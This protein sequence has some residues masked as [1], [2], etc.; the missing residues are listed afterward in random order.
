MDTSKKISVI[1]GV[2]NC[3]DTV[4]ESIES[5][6]SQTYDNWELIICDDC[7]TDNTYNTVKKYSSQYPE[8]IILI[9]NPTNSY[10]A[11]SL[12]HCL[13]YATGYYVA[14]MDGDDISRA[15]RFE[16]QVEYLINNPDVD[17]CGTAMQRFKNDREFTSVD[18]PLEEPDKFTMTHRT[19][20]NHATIMTYKKVYDELGGYYV[21]ERTIRGQ[22]ADL[23]YRF[24]SEGYV[25]KN[26]MEPLYF[27]REDE[28][29]I[30]RR[31]VKD[32]MM[33][34]KTAIFGYRL[35]H[36]PWYYY[37]GLI[38]FPIKMIIPYKAFDLLH[39]IQKK[40]K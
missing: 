40:S 39:K 19:P 12:N 20:F 18:Y 9:E 5:I 35:L 36:Y 4:G 31:T 3:E 6:I 23:W 29:A 27:V 21:S 24:Y 25:G 13:E 11:Y 10:L 32:R 2:Y 1:M 34:F 33:G 7:S 38:R 16:K 15:D 14:R 8:K 17:L 37:I 28:N 26:I 30:K 22:D